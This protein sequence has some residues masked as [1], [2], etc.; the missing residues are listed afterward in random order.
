MPFHLST[1]SC[2]HFLLQESKW[3]QIS[4][5]FVFVLFIALK[6]RDFSVIGILSCFLIKSVLLNF[7][8]VFE[9]LFI[10]CLCQVL[11]Q[12][13]ERTKFQ[14]KDI[15]TRHKWIVWVCPLFLFFFF[16]LISLKFLFQKAFMCSWGYSQKGLFWCADQR[17]RSVVRYW[18]CSAALCGLFVVTAVC[19]RQLSLFCRQQLWWQAGAVVSWGSRL[20]VHVYC[21]LQGTLTFKFYHVN[22]LIT[23]LALHQCTWKMGNLFLLLVHLNT[24]AWKGNIMP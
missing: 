4:D 23:L 17:A 9:S 1:Q 21:C 13:H 20:G 3:W 18:N 14:V 19:F 5:L 16:F 2:A 12:V 22:L 8:C 7:L 6:N 11:A 24:M 10:S 15:F